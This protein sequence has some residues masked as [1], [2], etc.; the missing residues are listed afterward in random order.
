[1][2]KTIWQ[3]Q[4]N[5]S[6]SVLH[7]NNIVQISLRLKFDLRTKSDPL[8]ALDTIHTV[9]KWGISDNRPQTQ[10]IG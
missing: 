10:H 9:K 5:I 3:G 1:M 7:I 8:R 6:C 2:Y 4:L